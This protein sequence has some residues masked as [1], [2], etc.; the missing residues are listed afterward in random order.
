MSR[1]TKRKLRQLKQ[2]IYIVCEATNTEPIYFEKIA[3]QPDVFE[4][5]AITVYPSEEDQIKA[6]TKGGESIKTDAV[7]LVKLAK[8]EI[9]NYDEVWAVFD[10]DGY[11][12]HEKAFSDAQKHGVKLGF[13]SIAFEH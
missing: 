12:K 3:E 8:D 9:K 6:S 10:K 11:T 4:K 5:Y 13:S 1:Q 2:S 7:N